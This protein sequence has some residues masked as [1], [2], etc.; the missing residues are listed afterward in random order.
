MAGAYIRKHASE[1]SRWGF[2]ITAQ[3][4]QDSR[5]F[6]FS[7]TAPNLSGSDA[8]CHLGPTDVSYLLPVGNGLAIQGGI[9]SSLIGYDSLYAKDNFNYTRPWGADFT[10]YL[11]LGVNASYP[12]NS[13]LTGTVFI[14]NGYFH[15]ANANGVPSWGGQLAYKANVCF[16]VQWLLS[17]RKR[18]NSKAVS[19]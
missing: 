9:F 19:D 1:Q 18:Q 14:I 5:I 3:A 10:P 4:G 16:T 12:F 6:G 17:E 8:L 7:A 2:E 13:K 15:L 11:M